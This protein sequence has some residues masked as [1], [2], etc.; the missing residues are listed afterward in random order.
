[1]SDIQNLLITE[2]LTKQVDRLSKVEEKLRIY[3][4]THEQKIQLLQDILIKGINFGIEKGVWLE[5]MRLSKIRQAKQQSMNK[6]VD[7]LVFS[8]NND[9]AKYRNQPRIKYNKR[10][11]RNRKR[12]GGIQL[13]LYELYGLT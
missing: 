11:Y 1:M 3:P 8:L 10:K 9:I 6:F 2:F 7:E 13:S 5:Q 4:M 12:D